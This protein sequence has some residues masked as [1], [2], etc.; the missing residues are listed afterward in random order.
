MLFRFS[1]IKLG[2][3]KKQQRQTLMGQ[4]THLTGVVDL[5][6]NVVSQGQKVIALSYH[7][8]HKFSQQAM[9]PLTR[10]NP[11][12]FPHK[13]EANDGWCLV[14]YA[15]GIGGGAIAV[16]AAPFALSAIG[17]TTAGV[18][19]GSVAAGIQSAVY[20]GAVASGSI[21]AGLQSAG[22]AGIG[23]KASA[24]IFSSVAG[25]ATY[26][27]KSVAPCEEGSKCYSHQE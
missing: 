21:F 20:G 5:M 14:D 18:A 24:A 15:M 7:S 1:V 8:F 23:V 3:V 13:D 6:E 26:I 17:F 12:V 9:R 11:F 10:D 25:A 4:Q 27:K 19:V 16:A 2:C 22:A